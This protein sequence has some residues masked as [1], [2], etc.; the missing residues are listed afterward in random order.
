MIIVITFLVN[1]TFL[2]SQKICL[3]LYL[4]LVFVFLCC[5]VV[6]GKIISKLFKTLMEYNL[7]M[8]GKQLGD[9]FESQH[10]RQIHRNLQENS[11]Y[12]SIK[13]A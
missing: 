12:I 7:R 9:I 13:F 6:C 1:Q 8:C 5:F 11:L 2:I 10:L 4:I 3:K